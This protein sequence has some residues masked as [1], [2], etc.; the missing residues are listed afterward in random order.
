[1]QRIGFG[2]KRSCGLPLTLIVAPFVIA[3]QFYLR[4]IPADSKKLKY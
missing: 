2:V 4:R 3:V 1:M